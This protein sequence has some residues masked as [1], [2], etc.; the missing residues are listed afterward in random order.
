MAIVGTRGRKRQR[1]P[2]KSGPKYRIVAWEKGRFHDARELL[3]WPQVM[4][5]LGNAGEGDIDEA[6]IYR[7]TNE[8]GT[9]LLGRE[10]WPLV[11][12][13]RKEGY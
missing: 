1:E 3:S 11:L 2:E 13:Y 9:Q 6:F 12:K 10:L 7:M 4:G 8:D 5:I